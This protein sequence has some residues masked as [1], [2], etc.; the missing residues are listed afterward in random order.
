M[1]RLTLVAL[2]LL[3]DPD[4]QVLALLPVDLV[5]LGVVVDE[6]A[7]VPRLVLVVVGLGDG[8]VGEVLVLVKLEDEA[9]AGLVQVL[10][11]D[12]GQVLECALV[13]VGDHLSE[14]D[15]VLHGG[16]PELWD[17][18]H[19]LVRLGWLL[20][21]LS[22]LVG[23][24]LIVLVLVLLILLAGLNLLLGGLGGTVD[25]VGTLLVQ[26]G[27]LG[28]V[29]L[30]QLEDLL[31]ELGL[32]LGVLLLDSLQAGDALLDLGRQ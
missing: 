11:A 24:L 18:V 32:K 16:Q 20:I 23:I 28:K 8:L 2:L 6:V 14:G 29:F 19:G 27:E 31:L 3:L 22:S 12:V 17:T 26:R 5:A 4:R 7:A 15:L 13:T 9:E 30:L 1:P 21:L 25:N 10:H